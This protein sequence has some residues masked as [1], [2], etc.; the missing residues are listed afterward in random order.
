MLKVEE[1][2]KKGLE[3]DNYNKIDKLPK[4]IQSYNTKWK[5]SNYTI[6]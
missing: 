5:K 1:K 2:I 6:L 4:Y 3:E